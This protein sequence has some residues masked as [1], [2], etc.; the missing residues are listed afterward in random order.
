MTAAGANLLPPLVAVPGVEDVS[1]SAT[2]EDSWRLQ[3][4]QTRLDEHDLTLAE[5]G[6]ALAVARDGLIIGE[7]VHADALYRLRLQLPSSSAGETFERLLLRGERP[8]DPAVYLRDVGIAVRET[9]PRERLRVDEVSA[10]E[11]TARWSDAQARDAL[12]RFCGDVV[13][14]EDFRR[15]CNVN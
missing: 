3:L 13:L 14:A 8:G 10:V 7:I 1:F 11:I 6:R 5:V 12:E 4:D 15:E 9:Q 2:D